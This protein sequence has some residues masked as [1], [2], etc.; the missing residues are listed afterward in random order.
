MNNKRG[1]L[2]AV[3]IIFIGILPV[4]ASSFGTRTPEMPR[5]SLPSSLK[6]L[7]EEA[8]SGTAVETLVLPDGLTHIGQRAFKDVLAL[9][10]LYIPKSSSEIGDEAIPTWTV[11]HGEEG[12]RAQ[13]WAKEAGIRF[14]VDDVWHTKATVKKTQ[15]EPFAVL[16][17]VLLP[18]DPK[19]LRRF[20]RC[21]AAF[22]RSMRPQD[23]AE[24]YVID[25]RFP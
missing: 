24:L 17:F 23:R 8:F 4:I 6:L 15:I 10:D 21:M 7:G 9:A 11:I 16:S 19:L 20:R 18:L 13:E 25:Y 2:A 12:S 5:S 22:L 3:M 14:V 1:F